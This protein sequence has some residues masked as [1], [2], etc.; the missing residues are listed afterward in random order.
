MQL[1]NII[2]ISLLQ[3]GNTLDGIAIAARVLDQISLSTSQKE[4]LTSP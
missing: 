3:T 2:M 4:Q 1:E